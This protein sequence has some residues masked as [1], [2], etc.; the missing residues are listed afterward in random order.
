MQAS[1]ASAN[2]RSAICAGDGCLAQA[3]RGHWQGGSVR[4]ERDGPSQADG[5]AKSRGYANLRAQFGADEYAHR[6]CAR[7]H[8]HAHRDG[9]SADSYAAA[10]A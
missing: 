2:G 8:E 9:H 7:T 10:R 3:N 5:F 1:E 4:S 6:F